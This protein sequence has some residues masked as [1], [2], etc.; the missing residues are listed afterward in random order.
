MIERGRIA[1]GAAVETGEIVTEERKVETET[2]IRTVV[3]TGLVGK[4][5]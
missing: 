3:G 4:R 1:L 5:R 2:R